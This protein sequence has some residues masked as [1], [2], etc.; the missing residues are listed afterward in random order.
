MK[1]VKTYLFILALLFSYG[2]LKT[3]PMPI[4]LMFGNNYGVFELS[5]NKSLVKESKL[6][7]FHMNSVEFGYHGE[8]SSII[9]QDL[10]YVEALKNL[11]VAGGLAYTPCGFNPTTGLHT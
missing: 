6:G 5:F 7:F 2:V 8:Y 10:L 1:I 11:R 9:F 4:E 3:Q